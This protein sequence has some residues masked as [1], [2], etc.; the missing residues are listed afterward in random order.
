MKRVRAAWGGRNVVVRKTLL[1]M[2]ALLF[3]VAVGVSGVTQTVPTAVVPSPDAELHA[4]LLTVKRLY[5][6]SFGDDAPSRQMQAFVIDS[7]TSSKRFIITE[8]K[9]KADAVVKG[10]GTELVSQE[11]RSTSEGTSIGAQR[12]SA[13][14]SESSSATQTITQ[15]KL[16]VRIVSADGDVLWSAEKESTGGKYKGS[17]A[18]VADDVI[19]QLLRDLNRPAS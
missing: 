5:V 2:A 8:N 12:S 16:A 7:L 1:S 19:K 13:G 18:T 6:D 9:D 3:S 17:A 15:A 10:V 11:Q 14:I 4:K